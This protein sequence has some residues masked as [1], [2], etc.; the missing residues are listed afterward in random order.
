MKYQKARD[1]CKETGFPVRAMMEKLV[2]CHLAPEFAFRTTSGQTAPWYIDT[3]KF[4]RMWEAGEFEEVLK[5]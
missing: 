5:G 3:E 2:H 1:F 4:K